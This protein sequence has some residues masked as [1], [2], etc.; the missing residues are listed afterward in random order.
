MAGA[1]QDPVGRVIGSR[2]NDILEKV[3]D[4]PPFPQ[5]ELNA[6]PT[7]AGTETKCRV[8]KESKAPTSPTP[9]A[10]KAQ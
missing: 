7:P 8:R 2:A 4:V 6:P 10:R 5:D 1:K 9:Q 3:K